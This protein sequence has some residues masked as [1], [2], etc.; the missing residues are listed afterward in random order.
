MRLLFGRVR[1]GR[2][3]GRPGCSRSIWSLLRKLGALR[4]QRADRRVDVVQRFSRLTGFF[5]RL[6]VLRVGQLRPALRFEAPAGCCRRPVRAGC[7]RA[8][9][10]PWS[11]R[12]RAGSG[13]RW[14]CSPEAWPTTT[15]TTASDQ[16]DGDRRPV[17]ARAEAADRVEGPGHRASSPTGRRRRRG[18]NFA[19]LEGLG[20]RF[21]ETGA[22]R[23]PAGRPGAGPGWRRSRRAASAASAT[24]SL[25]IALELVRRSSR[26][27]VRRGRA[28]TSSAWS[29]ARRC[30]SLPAS[31]RLR[32][33][34]PRIALVDRV[35][36][37][38]FLGAEAARRGRAA[39]R[40][41]AAA[42]WS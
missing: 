14:S 13:C 10:S 25:A 23:L 8:V 4:A 2:R 22:E 6:R 3:R 30:R 17:V 11:S 12:C 20:D 35:D 21:G 41:A 16:P 1:P 19:G 37:F 29:S 32:P 5:D 27:R 38:L 42:P 26:F 31:V 28:R 9:R 40:A 39:R 24:S 34:S 33:P 18:P 7:L 15:R 36:V